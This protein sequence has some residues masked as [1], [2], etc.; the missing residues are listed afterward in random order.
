[1][2][3]WTVGHCP[4]G[5]PYAPTLISTGMRMRMVPPPSLRTWIWPA[6]T[7]LSESPPAG[8]AR[9]SVA[10]SI[11]A[12]QRMRRVL[13][14]EMLD[15]A[16][17][18]DAFVRLPRDL[19]FAHLRAP[20]LAVPGQPDVL[21]S[22]RFV[23]GTELW[24][25]ATTSHELLNTG[26]PDEPDTVSVS[27]QTYGSL[28]EYLRSLF[29]RTQICF[30][31]PLGCWMIVRYSPTNALPGVGIEPQPAELLQRL[32]ARRARL[33]L[34]DGEVELLRD[35]RRRREAQAEID[36]R[37]FDSAHVALIA[38]LGDAFAHAGGVLEHVL[39]GHEHVGRD[40]EAGAVAEQAPFLR[41]TIRHTGRAAISPCSR[42]EMSERSLPLR[43]RSRRTRAASGS[44]R[45]RWMERRLASTC[46]GWPRAPRRTAPA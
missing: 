33:D 19:V 39:V 46:S 41:I 5:R 2:R 21:S 12:C 38:E 32:A 9:A 18:A 10:V 40:Q 25:S 24:C 27:Y 43:M 4:A 22:T 20:D 11:G 37:D 26:E 42:Y 14:R 15:D 1:M 31:S 44:A 30:R 29:S 23:S 35:D 8:A 28:S 7:T 13:R 34:D 3:R 36:R 16:A 17:H 6:L 45:S